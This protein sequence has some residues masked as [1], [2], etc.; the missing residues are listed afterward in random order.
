[1]VTIEIRSE[2][3]LGILFTPSSP[4]A[5]AAGGRMTDTAADAATHAE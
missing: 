5:A 4:A 3:F 1:L 2:G